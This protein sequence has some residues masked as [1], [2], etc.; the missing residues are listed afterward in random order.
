MA[1]E[2][3]WEDGEW[4]E[5]NKHPGVRCTRDGRL[6]TAVW[7]VDELREWILRLLITK[8][9]YFFSSVVYI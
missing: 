5:G 3:G 2:V 9:I 7:C 4:E 8:R 6:S 1:P